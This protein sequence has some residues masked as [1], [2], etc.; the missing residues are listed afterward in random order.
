MLIYS[1][2]QNSKISNYEVVF[3]L[4]PSEIL[5]LLE[6]LLIIQKALK[7]IGGMNDKNTL[8]QFSL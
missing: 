1:A 4:Q 2:I 3:Q 5:I 7:E 6:R 8:Y